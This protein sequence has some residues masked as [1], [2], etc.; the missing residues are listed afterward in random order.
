MQAIS[1]QYVIDKYG[2]ASVDKM[3]TLT[4]GQSA[5]IRKGYADIIIK[6]CPVSACNRV[7]ASYAG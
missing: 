4:A 7:P 5:P 2:K 1:F 3:H 6:I